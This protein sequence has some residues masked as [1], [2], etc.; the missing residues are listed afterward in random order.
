MEDERS[1]SIHAM[2]LAACRPDDVYRRPRICYRH[3]RGLR[4]A[5]LIFRLSSQFI[6]VRIVSTRSPRVD[7]TREGPL[8]IGGGPSMLEASAYIGCLLE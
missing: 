7:G 1:L 3:S 6:C 8:P 5:F 2:S 4:S